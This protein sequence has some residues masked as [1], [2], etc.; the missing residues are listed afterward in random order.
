MKVVYKV[1]RPVPGIMV[2]QN[3]EESWEVL[4]FGTGEDGFSCVTVMSE[5]P[6]GD[7]GRNV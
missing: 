3:K 4:S 6:T 2:V 1:W 5:V 7:L